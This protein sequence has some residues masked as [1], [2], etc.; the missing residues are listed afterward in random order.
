MTGPYA[1]EVSADP[2]SREV[3][4]ELTEADCSVGQ[5]QAVRFYRSN[6]GVGTLAGTTRCAAF[7]VGSLLAPGESR[8]VEVFGTDRGQRTRAAQFTVK[9]ERDGAL[10]STHGS[11]TGLGR[12]FYGA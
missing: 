6:W 5:A 7:A 8:S 2:F 10:V 12:A 9:R 1:V 4:L 3:E 11:R